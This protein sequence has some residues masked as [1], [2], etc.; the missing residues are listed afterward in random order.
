MKL[1]LIG[2][3]LMIGCGGTPGYDL[4]IA[5]PTVDA[6]DSGIDSSAD[7][8]EETGSVS[9]DAGKE[10]GSSHNDASLSNT[11]SGS[12]V[13]VDAGTTID[14]GV[15]NDSGHV[16]NTDS[17]QSI[18]AGSVIDSGPDADSGTPLIITISPDAS[19]C[20]TACFTN[21]NTCIIVQNCLD[22]GAW[23]HDCVRGC[24]TTLLGCNSSCVI[25]NDADVCE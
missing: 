8:G 14:S 13:A 5:N 18:D 10:T 4:T 7:S 25:R 22:A 23:Q 12:P 3:M 1:K 15:T 2:C 16:V 11:D 24:N 9:V 20:C 19:P 6:S 17:G 21:Y